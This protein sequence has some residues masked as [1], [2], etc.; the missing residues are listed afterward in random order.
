MNENV[1][2][3]VCLTAIFGV[4]A[5]NMI[6]LKMFV[7][8]GDI[9]YSATVGL[10]VLYF[11]VLQALRVFGLLKMSALSLLL[12]VVYYILWAHSEKV[13]FLLNIAFFVSAVFTYCL[14]KKIDEISMKNDEFKGVR[15]YT[16]I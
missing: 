9:P 12:M 11:A 1:K 16:D 8:D 13:I 6:C 15:F 4:L 10:S 7:E 5:L 3:F 14:I 2:K